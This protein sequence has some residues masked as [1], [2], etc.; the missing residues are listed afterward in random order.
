MSEFSVMAFWLDVCHFHTQRLVL[1]LV[2]WLCP[3]M[4]TAPMHGLMRQPFDL[5]ETIFIVCV[6][7]LAT[8]SSFYV[9]VCGLA[10]L[11]GKLSFIMFMC[12]LFILPTSFVFCVCMLWN[13]FFIYKP[14]SLSCT[15]ASRIEFSNLLHIRYT[16]SF[17]NGYRS[18]RY[19]S[20]SIFKTWF[21]RSHSHW[22]P[23]L[24]QS[25][26][27]IKMTIISQWVE[28]ANRMIPLS[29]SRAQSPDEHL[30]ILLKNI[31]LLS[32][33]MNGT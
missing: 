26:P 1:V 6:C 16:I 19:T 17:M 27:I 23:M 2:L 22:S 32:D 10:L 8:S 7:V 30:K 14:H 5:S 4:H 25:L 18:M 12:G 3:R 11:T 29:Y 28:N 9:L 31:S 21:I 33:A 20:H 24:H 13:I 15:N